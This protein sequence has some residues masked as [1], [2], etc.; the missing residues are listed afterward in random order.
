MAASPYDAE[1]NSAYYDENDN[2]RCT[3]HSK[4]F[5]I[6]LLKLL[7]IVYTAIICVMPQLWFGSTSNLRMERDMLLKKVAFCENETNITAETIGN[8]FDMKH[9]ILRYNDT[10]NETLDLSGIFP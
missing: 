4:R 9:V 10:A 7:L 3:I 5:R 1:N 8:I 6:H 2:A